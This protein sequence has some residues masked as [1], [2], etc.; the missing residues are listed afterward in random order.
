MVIS[1]A[2]GRAAS[3]HACCRP[4]SP[5]PTSNQLPALHT[6]DHNDDRTPVLA[7]RRD[8]GDRRARA[9]RAR[10]VRDGAAA[11]PHPLP[12][13]LAVRRPV[14]ALPAAGRQGLFQAGGPGRHRRRRQRLGRHGHARRLRRVRHG[15]RRHQ[16]DDR[17]PR[18]QPGQPLG[19]HAGRLHALR[20][21]AR[22]RV[23]AQEVGHHQAGG[24]QRQ[25]DGRAGVRRRAPGVPDLREGEQPR[26]VEDQVAVD[27][28]AAPRDD[29][30]ARRG[31]RDHRLLLHQPPQPQRARRQGRGRRRARN[32]R[33]TG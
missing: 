8:P 9:R 14:G 17:V 7:P 22:G 11:D 6:E 16:R 4:C 18:D 33:T 30:R 5:G 29:A 27:G 20:R 23:R 13:R 26:L 21:D 3:W 25:D 15:L 1:P 28:S 19:A 12:A 32:T 24:P 10:R 2:P 31:R